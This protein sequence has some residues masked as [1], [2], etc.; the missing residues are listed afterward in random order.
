[1]PIRWPKRK[2]TPFPTMQC[3]SATNVFLRSQLIQQPLEMHKSRPEWAVGKHEGSLRNYTSSFMH[4]KNANFIY[5]LAVIF[6]V[7]LAHGV[8]RSSMLG[9]SLSALNEP[10]RLAICWLCRDGPKSLMTPREQLTWK[11]GMAGTLNRHLSCLWRSVRQRP[12]LTHR[13]PCFLSPLL[14]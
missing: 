9:A 13:V 1:M 11:S 7:T 14:T 3:A 12:S 5:T 8:R 2:K 6:N 10:V 4:R